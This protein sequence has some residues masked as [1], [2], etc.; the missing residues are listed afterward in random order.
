MRSVCAWCGCAFTPTAKQRHNM[1][2]GRPVFCERQCVIFHK[3]SRPWL[4]LGPC[5]TCGDRFRS[6]TSKKYCSLKCYIVSPQL[7][8]QARE[9]NRKRGVAAGGRADG[10]HDCRCLYCGSTWVVSRLLKRRK[11]CSGEHRRLY[12]AE[13]FD[14]WV[15]SPESIALPQN[16]DEFLTQEELPCLVESCDWSG[17]FLTSHMN[18]VHGVDAR[19]FKES[20]GFN[21]GTGVISLP[22]HRKMRSWLRSGGLVPGVGSP[23][24]RNKYRSLESIEHWLKARALK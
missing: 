9:N 12:F 14:R 19:T 3:T 10:G 6:K 5:P 13:R 15:A 7:T 22:L 20:A 1:R 16:Y 4:D 23:G 11:F 17:Q 8:E 2:C 18:L 24:R 21:L